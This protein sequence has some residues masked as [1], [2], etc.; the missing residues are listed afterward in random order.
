MAQ[1]FR[2]LAP[3]LAAVG[4]EAA[5]LELVAKAIADEERHAGIC[6]ELAE[7]YAKRSLTPRAPLEPLEP[8]APRGGTLPDFGTG[9]EAL[10]VALLVLGMSCINES[11]ACE[12]LRASYARATDRAA[13]EVHRAHL[14]DEIDHARLGWA[15]FASRAV[16]PALK[17][18]IR[19]RWVERVLAANVT[20]WQKPDEHLPPEGVPELG[21]LSHAESLEAIE[22]AVSDVIRPGLARV[23]L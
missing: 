11:I 16:S 13:A 18:D 1:A 5:V 7:R 15:H 4:A 6:V 17:A 21:H 12:W 8:L 14:K 2:A 9:D 3:R 10:E 22:A 20:E 23:G 19:E